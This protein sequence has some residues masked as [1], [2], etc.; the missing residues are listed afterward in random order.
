MAHRLK[1]LNVRTDYTINL[2]PAEK[3]F[4]F[5]NYQHMTIGDMSMKLNRKREVLEEFM[6]KYGLIG[7]IPSA[8]A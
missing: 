2:R 6:K 1:E 3:G 7:I 5:N 4:I 8:T